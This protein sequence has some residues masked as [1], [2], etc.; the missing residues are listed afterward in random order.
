MFGDQS[1]TFCGAPV[2]AARRLWVSAFAAAALGISAFPLCAADLRFSRSAVLPGI[3]LQLRLM[4]DAT[5]KPLPPETL[6]PYLKRYGA[7]SEKV[8]LYALHDLWRHGQQAAQWADAGSNTLTIAML[9]HSLPRFEGRVHVAREDY[10]AQLA[11]CATA[12]DEWT[13]RDLARWALDFT[14]AAAVQP[15]D[16]PPRLPQ[17]ARIVAFTFQDQPRRLAYAF[18]LRTSPQTVAATNWLFALIDVGPQV[19]MKPA[20]QAV[21]RQFLPY[22]SAAASAHSPPG[23]REAPPAA[24]TAEKDESRRQVAASVANLKGWWYAE[25][26]GYIILSN[27][28]GTNRQFVR[29]LQSDL[30]L[31]SAGFERAIPARVPVRAVSVIRVFDTPEEYAAYVGPDQQWT[32][33]L[34][35]PS[36][37]ELVIRPPQAADSPEKRQRVARAIYHEALHQ[38]LFYAL[39]QASASPWFNEGYASLFEAAAIRNGRIRLGEDPEKIRILESM[40]AANRCDI[41]RLLTLSH[42]AF[43]AET[44]KERTENYVLAWALIYY[45][46]KAPA[47]DKPASYGE[48]LARY[49]DA[50]WKTEDPDKATGAAMAGVEVAALQRDFTAFWQSARKRAAAARNDL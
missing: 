27:M 48:I 5:E 50:L 33:G 43:Y 2:S 16:Y 45:L 23:A 31:L 9:T 36:R 8:D 34:W 30:E 15:A 20:L 26:T 17:L 19:D 42:S 35:L 21:E 6:Y 44:E 18:R 24:G 38:Y 14:R 22:L 13:D 3:G 40:L 28:R 46:H 10:D 49:A 41:S 4:P 32:A 25:T 39:D 37:R 7:V 47:S 29:D 1:I 11:S 12:A